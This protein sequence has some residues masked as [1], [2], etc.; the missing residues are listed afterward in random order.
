VTGTCAAGKYSA[1]TAS[2]CTS[3]S[4]G[5]YQGTAGL[6][7]CTICSWV[8]ISIFFCSHPEPYRWF[9]KIKFA[10][11]DSVLVSRLSA[12]SNCLNAHLFIRT[13]VLYLTCDCVSFCCFVYVNTLDSSRVPTRLRAPPSARA[14]QLLT[15]KRQAAS[16]AALHVPLAATVVRPGSLR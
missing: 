2:V 1:L 15:S 5:Y 3:C 16:R 13:S 14:V 9:Q 8:R 11:V 12:R 10:D 4:A 7:S 6:S